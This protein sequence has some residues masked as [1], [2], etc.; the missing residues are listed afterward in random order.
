MSGATARPGSWWR[1]NRWGVLLLPVA[2]ALA[3]VA[4]SS[5]VVLFW[6]PYGPH[7]VT[8]AALAQP[9]GVQEQWLD[10]AGTHERRLSVSVDS[11]SAPPATPI[12]F[13]GREVPS[14]VV[15][16]E[17][18]GP[19]GETTVTLTSPPGTRIWQVTL[20]VVADPDQVLAGCRVAIVDTQGRVYD[21]DVR[22]IEPVRSTLKT[23]PCVP[24]GAR[25][26]SAVLYDGMAQDPEE[27]DRP[28]SYTTSAYLAT[29]ADA[30]PQTV[31]FWF[32]YPRVIEVSVPRP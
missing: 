3:V 25:G 1:S 9:V 13:Q 21:S 27:L 20:S 4:S 30:V 2:A 8:R 26:P 6:W 18:P 14:V 19:R 29:A 16:A 17:R 22:M 11:V 5:R 28:A 24:D 32:E 12:R 15:P 23:T 31:R 7:E 10:R